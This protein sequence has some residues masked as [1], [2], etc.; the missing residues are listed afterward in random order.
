[1]DLGGDSG[2]GDENDHADSSRGN[3]E[4]ECI[5][6]GKSELIWEE[7]Q[8]VRNGS[9]PYDAHF[10]AKH[11][12]SSDQQSTERPYTTT[13]TSATEQHDCPSPSLDVAERLPGLIPLPNLTTSGTHVI[14]PQ[15]LDSDSSIIAV[16]EES[17]RVG[18][19]RHHEPNQRNTCDGDET[20]EHED[21]LVRFDDVS[22]LRCQSDPVRNER[23]D[24]MIK[25]GGKKKKKEKGGV[26]TNESVPA[27]A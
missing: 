20:E 7:N 1:L 12:H 18:W 3:A 10:I 17:R 26:E 13:W 8:I 21:A 27:V 2:G 19:I 16:L 6:V 15:P 5:E 9:L 11:T 24:L 23:T 22:L 25:K 4:Q 14:I